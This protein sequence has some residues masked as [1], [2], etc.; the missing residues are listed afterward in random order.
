MEMMIEV[1]KL[2]AEQIMVRQD[3][4]KAAIKLFDDENTIPFIA[5]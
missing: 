2:I 3:Q 4:V 5:R 1:N